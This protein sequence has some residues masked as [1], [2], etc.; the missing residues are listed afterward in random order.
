MNRREQMR[1]RR[2]GT[3]NDLMAVP[4]ARPTHR[5]NG[6]RLTPASEG[7]VLFS[8]LSWDKNSIVRANNRNMSPSAIGGQSRARPIQVRSDPRPS[9]PSAQLHRRATWGFMWAR[10][11]ASLRTWNNRVTSPALPR[12]KEPGDRRQW[13]MLAITAASK[14]R[15]NGAEGPA[16]ISSVMSSE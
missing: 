15:I 8:V 4:P 10:L 12:G 2:F 3:T 11:S 5:G 6:L 9:V 13:A 14:G 16:R 1:E 7:W